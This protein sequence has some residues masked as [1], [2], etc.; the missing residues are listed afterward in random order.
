MMRTSI[1]EEEFVTIV[2]F[3]SGLSLDIRNRVEL[4]PYKDFNIY[5]KYALR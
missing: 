3:L 1:R 4:L 5:F 2:R